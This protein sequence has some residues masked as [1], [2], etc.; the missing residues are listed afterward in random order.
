[1]DSHTTTDIGD[2][3]RPG[4]LICRSEDRAAVSWHFTDG[5]L[6]TVAPT[7]SSTN[8]KQVKSGTGVIPGVSRLSLNR[9]NIQRSDNRT[10]GLW[11]CWLNTGSTNDEQVHV[12][13][14]SGGT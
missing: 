9:E 2:P 6:V 8:F 14:F 4:A 10:N 1:M 7:S 3:N 11:H 13:I 5:I 12:G